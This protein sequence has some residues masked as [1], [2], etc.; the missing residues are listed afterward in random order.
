MNSEIVECRSCQEQRLADASASRILAGTGFTYTNSEEFAPANY[1][2][3][4]GG[5]CPH[6]RP[7]SN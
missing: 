4:I 2:R 6:V 3:D 1:Y 5:R 7:E